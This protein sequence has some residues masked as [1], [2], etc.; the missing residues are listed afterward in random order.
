MHLCSRR[1]IDMIG[2]A[3]SWWWCEFILYRYFILQSCIQLCIN[4]INRNGRDTYQM[5]VHHLR[6]KVLINHRFLFVHCTSE[7]IMMMIYVG[8][9]NWNTF[10]AECVLSAI[11]SLGSRSSWSMVLPTWHLIMLWNPHFSGWRLQCRIFLCIE[12]VTK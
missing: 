10:S 3:L 4:T 6:W 12:T 11:K 1:H 9:W 8:I 5:L 2:E 7:Q